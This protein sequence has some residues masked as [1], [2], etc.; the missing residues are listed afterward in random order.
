MQFG[1][2]TGPFLTCCFASRRE[3][4]AQSWFE[5]GDLLHRTALAL[6]VVKKQ[7]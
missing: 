7:D 6:E 5:V 4:S 2:R 3:V 1:S